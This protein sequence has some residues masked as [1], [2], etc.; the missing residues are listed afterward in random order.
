MIVIVRPCMDN[1]AADSGEKHDIDNEDTSSPVRS[2]FGGRVVLLRVCEAESA[3]CRE[4]CHRGEPV[5]EQDG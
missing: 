1:I 2:S 3:P 4:D 5:A